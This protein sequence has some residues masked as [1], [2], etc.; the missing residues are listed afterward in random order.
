MRGTTLRTVDQTVITIPNRQ[1][2]GE[3]LTNLTYGL[4]HVRLMVEV[5]V[6]YDSDA[7]KVARVLQDV[8]R[9]DPRVLADPRPVVR[10][11]NFGAS[12]LDFLLLAFTRN[13][14]DR[15]QIQADLRAAVLQA[16]REHKI[17]IPFPQ[18]DLR[19]TYDMR[20][21]E[22]REQARRQGAA[23]PPLASPDRSAPHLP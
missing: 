5:G 6:A 23:F 8:A 10:L 1:I 17:E 21:E 22:A 20:H 11:Q 2:I 13:L 15:L 19:I 4:Q 7:V 16:F 18:H 9:R 14:T 12:S 3:R